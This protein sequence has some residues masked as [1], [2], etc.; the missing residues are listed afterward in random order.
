MWCM[1]ADSWEE[2]P[3]ESSSFGTPLEINSYFLVQRDD[4]F[5]FD[6]HGNLLQGFQKGNST[7]SDPKRKTIWI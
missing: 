1:E 4:Q 6:G 7:I 2:G 5:E 3:T